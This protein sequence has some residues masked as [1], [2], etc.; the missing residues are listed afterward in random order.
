M[1]THAGSRGAGV[2]RPTPTGE[3]P[4]E[5]ADSG[6]ALHSHLPNPR[7]V[8]GGSTTGRDAGES[9]VVESEGYHTGGQRGGGDETIGEDRDNA[10]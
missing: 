3:V 9:A 5:T 10:E 2:V 8:S 1:V 6:G 7:V 4:R